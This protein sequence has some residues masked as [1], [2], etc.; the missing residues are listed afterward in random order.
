[1]NVNKVDWNQK[2]HRKKFEKILR[3]YVDFESKAE[4]ENIFQSLIEELHAT[5]RMYTYYNE[6]LVIYANDIICEEKV[7]SFVSTCVN[8]TLM[9]SI[10]L[11]LKIKK[12]KEE[13]H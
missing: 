8:E 12:R 2:E 1:M 5:H 10:Y 11:L 13:E 9:K 6:E 7:N 4:L 3:K